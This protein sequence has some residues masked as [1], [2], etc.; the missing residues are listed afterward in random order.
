[1]KLEKTASSST[2]SGPYEVAIAA[3]L[4]DLARATHQSV[5]AESRFHEANARVDD[6]V[7]LV[8]SLLVF[9]PKAQSAQYRRKLRELEAGRG[10]PSRGGPAFENVVSLFS[11][12]KGERSWTPKQVGDALTEKGR[13][14]NQKA[15]YNVLNYMAK[16]GRLKRVSRGRYVVADLGIGIETSDELGELG[17][18]GD[19]GE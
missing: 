1:M 2:E 10:K 11:S 4:D 5:L 19:C 9:I 3:A 12:E 14:T 7:D 6:L 18:E 16:T 15:V 17:D 8:E 13:T